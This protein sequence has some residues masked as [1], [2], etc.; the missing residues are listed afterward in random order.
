MQQREGK[1]L[2]PSA[3]AGAQGAGPAALSPQ[4]PQ[5]PGR[6]R[7]QAGPAEAGRGTW[8]RRRGPGPAS[9]RRR[10]CWRRRP[11]GPRRVN[12]SPA[13]A[14]PDPSRYR[15][16]RRQMTRRRLSR[17]GLPAES[18]AAPPSVCSGR[19]RVARGRRNLSTRRVALLALYARGV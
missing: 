17:L 11:A 16:T 13:V 12:A 5:H 10:C 15:L 7:Q 8:W 19:R 6:P 1:R 14:D 2:P 4:E 3:G 18:D 9:R